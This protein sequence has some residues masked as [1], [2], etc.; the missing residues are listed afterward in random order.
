MC[1]TISLSPSAVPVAVL[2]VS[3]Q[4]QVYVLESISEQYSC[5]RRRSTYP[6]LSGIGDVL[7]GLE[8]RADV[9]G[10]TTPEMPVNGPIKGKLQ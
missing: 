1:P 10:L 4:F 8:E 9:D 5:D 6:L 2:Y 7:V 3:P